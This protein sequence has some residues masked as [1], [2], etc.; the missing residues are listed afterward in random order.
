LQ[1]QQVI[2]MKAGILKSFE[3]DFSADII[4]KSN[5]FHV[6]L[7]N[8]HV[9]NGPYSKIFHSVL[10]FALQTKPISSYHMHAL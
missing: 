4:N 9:Q 2:A 7:Q 6:K 8:L 3:P 1:Q 10:G 5:L